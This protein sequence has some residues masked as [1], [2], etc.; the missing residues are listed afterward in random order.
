MAPNAKE[1]GLY[2]AADMTE[3]KL[4]REMKRA[5]FGLILW[6]LG[7]ICAAAVSYYVLYLLFMALRYHRHHF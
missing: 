2:D 3:D 5:A 6:I 4:P 7:G 1:Q